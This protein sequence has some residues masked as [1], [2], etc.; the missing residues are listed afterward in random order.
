MSD[1]NKMS[2]LFMECEEEELEPWQK[3]APVIH[4]IDDDD[5]EPIFVGILSHNNKPSPQAAQTNRRSEIRRASPAAGS[6][7]VLPLKIT[8]NTVRPAAPKPISLAPRP[9]I[10]NNKGY[11]VPSPLISDS[12]FIASIGKQLPA[13]GSLTI[14]PAGQS[15]NVLQVTQ[16]SPSAIHRPQVQQLS[17]NILKLSS[18]PSPTNISLQSVPVP[19]ASDNRDPSAEKRGLQ[20]EPENSVAKKA[21]MQS[22]QAGITDLEENAI[23]K[24]KCPKCNDEFLLSETLQSHMKTCRV[25]LDRPP[26]NGG[27]NKLVMLVSEFYYGT[28]EGNMQGRKA[29]PNSTFKCTCCFKVLKNNIRFMNHMKHHLEL[30]KQSSE[31]WDSHTT[32]QHCYRQYMTPFQ[33]QCHIESAHSPIESSTNCKI[34]EL[35]FASEQVLL[36]HMK[37]I[38]K[39]GEMPYICQV[40]GFRSSFFS[41][42][43]QHFRTVHDST[44]DLLCPFCLRVLRSSHSYMQHYMRHQKKGI[45]R[46]GK[47]RLN[48]LTHKEKADH[49]TNSHKTFRKPKALEGL[50]PGTKVTIR[51]SLTGKSPNVQNHRGRSGITIKPDVLFPGQDNSQGLAGKTKSNMTAVGKVKSVQNKKQAGVSNKFNFALA[52]LSGTEGCFTCV[53]CNSKVEDFFSHFPMN[54]SCGACKY[55]TSCKVS[56]GNHMIRFHST[57]S[58]NRISKMNPKKPSAMKITL[59]CT[60]C[61]LILDASGGD[62]MTKHLLDRPNHECRAI[63]DKAEVKEKDQD[64]NGRHPHASSHSEPDANQDP[65]PK[66][67]DPEPSESGPLDTKSNSAPSPKQDG[68]DNVEGPPAPE[69]RESPHALREE[70]KPADG[71]E[72]KDEPCVSSTE[73]EVQEQQ[74]PDI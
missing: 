43:E 74:Q 42:M 46:C 57:I 45:H 51:A 40:C 9:I 19:L 21:K 53:E 29:E 34:C 52:N 25:S 6:S 2:E 54:S 68:E 55:R 23:L 39:P 70:E 66:E 35:A 58:K 60:N 72:V 26:V 71:S 61:D 59:L 49:R 47:C 24:N 67:A 62:L 38:H 15:S 63:M 37:N 11:I 69:E 48:F 27:A 65:T 50:A 41:V 28:C 8:G 44:R 16:G 10:V 22:D 56:Y 17:N 32:C 30:E 20:L 14:V 73:Q 7:P 36:E 3:P 13:G 12:E 31:S 33:L 4:V 64:L 1:S 18:V 5:D